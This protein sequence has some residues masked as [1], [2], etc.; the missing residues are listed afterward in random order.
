MDILLNINDTNELIS[1]LQTVNDDA[2]DNFYEN[3]IKIDKNRES[4]LREKVVVVPR[5]F[6][7]SMDTVN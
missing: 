4:L 7:F 5:M 3:Q 2:L 1:D 6:H